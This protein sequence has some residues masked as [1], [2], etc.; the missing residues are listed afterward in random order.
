MIDSVNEFEMHVGARLLDF[1]DSRSTWDRKLWNVGLV[2]TLSE[3]VEAL[4]GYRVGVLSERSLRYLLAHAQKAA[5]KDP[6]AGS[7]KERQLLQGALSSKPRL[8]GFGHHLIVRQE[9]A[10]RPVYLDR[11]AEVLRQEARPGP[12]R[13]AHS[14]AS[15]LLDIGYSSDYLHCWWKYRLFHEET[16]RPLADLVD[17]A[18][19]LALAPQR[20]FEVLAPVSSAIHRRHTPPAEWQTPREVSRWLQ[21]NGFDTSGVRQSGGFLFRITALDPGAAVSRTTE[22]LD[23]LSAR[24]AVGTKSELALLD[25]VWVKGDG[26]PRRVDS[27]R[28]GVLVEALE[29][30]NQLYDDE[31][32]AHLQISSSGAAVA[33]GW[34]AIE[35]TSSGGIHAAIELLAHLQIS[36]SGAAVAGG[37]AAIEALLSEPS[38]RAG[39]AERL[40]M[41]VACSIPRAELTRLS[42]ALPRTSL[43]AELRSVNSNQ[44]R[45]YIAASAIAEGRID[46]ST[47][48]P[49]DRAALA[50]I[51]ELLSN[52][53]AAL[54][55]VCD[56]ASIAFRRLYRQRNIVLHWGRTDGVALQ[57]SLRTAAPLVGAGIDRI[58]HAHYVDGLSPLQLVARAKVS[59][60]TVGTKS[61]PACTR[62]LNVCKT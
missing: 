27:V 29:R 41:L 61:G 37:W 57:A 23:Q 38:D 42:Y 19:A 24:M 54:D 47:L 21:E 5:G 32:L 17:D 28:R 4:E 51:S 45:C 22:I 9:A 39:A 46:S 62:L 7:P 35:A 10:I 13:T 58:I 1:F 53:A 3:V 18:Q 26:E 16:R 31:L 14:I 30:E 43:S 25:H 6:G 40:A 36:S 50:R 8:G 44:A 15:H 52:P 55:T 49:S 20:T 11:W 48:P 60:A 56:Y 12:E 34:A 33:G 2:L 59:L